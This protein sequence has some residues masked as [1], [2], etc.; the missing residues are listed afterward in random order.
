M[1]HLTAPL[2]NPALH[3][4]LTRLA[5]AN[6]G[7]SLSTALAAGQLSGK[8]HA[9]MITRCRACP[10]AFECVEALAEGQVPLACANRSRLFEL[11]GSQA[12][13][14]GRVRCAVNAHPTGAG[15]VA[16]CGAQGMRTQDS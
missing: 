13:K 15:G 16:I 2:G 10:F 1:T 9:A 7:A 14:V 12:R 3:F 8:D 4:E 11:A 5:A 6:L